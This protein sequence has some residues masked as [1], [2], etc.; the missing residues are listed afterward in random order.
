MRPTKGSGGGLLETTRR[1][2]TASS[3]SKS[4]ASRP[5]RGSGLGGVTLSGDIAIVGAM[6]D[7]NPV[8]VVEGAAQLA[9]TAS[10]TIAPRARR[11]RDQVAVISD[12]G[13]FM[14][15]CTSESETVRYRPSPDGIASSMRCM[16]ATSDR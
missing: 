7:I 16:R 5:T 8:E 13:T 6:L 9:T 14:T 10:P 15:V 12:T 3:A 4:P 11:P 1:F 2:Q